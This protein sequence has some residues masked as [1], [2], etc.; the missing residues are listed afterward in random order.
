MSS[1]R[2]GDRSQ[3]VVESSAARG[4]V[5][6]GHFAHLEKAFDGKYKATGFSDADFDIAILALRLGGK[7]L[8][9]SLSQAEGFPGVSTVYDKMRDSTV[10][11]SSIW[12]SFSATLA[13]V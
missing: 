2:E 9:Y 6:K 5:P 3:E 1:E 13:P 8:L 12:R 10:R 11:H 7:A 4:L